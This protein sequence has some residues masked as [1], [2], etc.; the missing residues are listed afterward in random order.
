MQVKSPQA[1]GRKALRLVLSE[2]I[3]P[4]GARR[5]APTEVV[6][7]SPRDGYLGRSPGEPVTIGGAYPAR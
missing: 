3:E 1:G 4:E 6:V 7:R 5:C 2:A